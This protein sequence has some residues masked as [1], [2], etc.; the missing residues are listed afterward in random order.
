[1]SHV[2]PTNTRDN[3]KKEERIPL[4]YIV[5]PDIG[6]MTQKVMLICMKLK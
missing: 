1:M 6:G 4:I 3:T 2:V 5:V